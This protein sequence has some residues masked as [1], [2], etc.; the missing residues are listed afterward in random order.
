MN[1]TAVT[2]AA[3]ALTGCAFCAHA[4]PVYTSGS[5]ALAAFTSATTPVATTT[6]FPL[7]DNPVPI[8]SPVGSF[9]MVSLP[10]SL[11]LGP[12]NPANFAT[13]ASLDF[14][15]AGLGAFAATTA[16]SV[17]SP[18]NVATWDV[19]GTFTLGPDWANS[20]TSMTANEIWSL[21]Q[22]G[23]PGNAISISATFE[24]ADVIP[25]PVTL[26]LFGSGL[27]GLAMARRRKDDA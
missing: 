1:R 10:P 18:P 3:A 16:T 6:D 8:G 4:N 5:F 13:P 24:A 21:T 11:T 17:A 12:P 23:G 7:T 14:T 2:L 20:G 9:T 25:E 22:S 26:A 19:V 15:D 27:V